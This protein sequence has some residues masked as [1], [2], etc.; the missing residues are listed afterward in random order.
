M[1][2]RRARYV[3]SVIKWYIPKLKRSSYV[4][5]YISQEN[6]SRLFES[7]NCHFLSKTVLPPK[8]TFL[9]TIDVDISLEIIR[10]NNFN[11]GDVEWIWN[12]VGHLVASRSN[13]ALLTFCRW[14][15][16]VLTIFS[17]VQLFSCVWLFVT[18]W[19]AARQLPCPSPIPWACSNSCPLS[20]WCHPTISF[21]VVPFFC[22]QSF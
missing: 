19:T 8:L 6:I 20:Q 18:P 22:L 9:T 21:S 1:P 13:S 14:G 3:F 2:Q 17:S 12:Q 15:N 7:R 16:W 10:L 4:K 5:E 11:E